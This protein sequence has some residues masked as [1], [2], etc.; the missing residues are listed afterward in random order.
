MPRKVKYLDKNYLNQINHI[1][2][3]VLKYNRTIPQSVIDALPEDKF[4]PIMFTMLHEHKAGKLCDPHMRCIIAVPVNETD[5]DEKLEMT[6]LILDMD[7]ALFDAL[8]EV[9][10]PD[11]EPEPVG[12]A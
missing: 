2:T 7:Y 1:S 8:P 11:N 6:Q 4:F 10:V 3:N 5:D 12:T 9:D